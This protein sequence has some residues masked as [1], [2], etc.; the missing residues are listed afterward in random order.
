LMPDHPTA[1]ALKTHV[2]EPV[3]FV[4][5]FAKEQRNNG[6]VGY[7]EKDAAKTGVVAKQA[8]RLMEALIE[9]RSTWTE[10]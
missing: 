1:I 4:L 2:A 7:N 10:T 8:F 6:A 5:F 9:G 3:P